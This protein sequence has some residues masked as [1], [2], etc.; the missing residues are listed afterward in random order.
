MLEELR[1]LAST[2]DNT[3]A[4]LES[5]N[6]LN[7]TGPAGFFPGIDQLLAPTRN[8]ADIA[9]KIPSIIQD[10]SSWSGG[11]GSWNTHSIANSIMQTLTNNRAMLGTAGELF[12]RNTTY[13]LGRLA[14]GWGP[15]VTPGEVGWPIYIRSAAGR[16]VESFRNMD[17][18]SMRRLGSDVA[19]YIAP[20]LQRFGQLSG[21][22]LVEALPA[23]ALG[24]VLGG[25]IN[26]VRELVTNQPNPNTNIWSGL[27]MGLWLGTGNDLNEWNS[28]ITDPANY[29]VRN[30]I[31]DINTQINPTTATTLSE[32]ATADPYAQQATGAG[33]TVRGQTV[34]NPYT[35]EAT[36]Q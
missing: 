27:D 8:F 3:E 5:I 10:Y 7:R 14:G 13:H 30:P 4:L 6:M 35:G 32:S 20:A 18:E 33:Q 34:V 31:T 12:D 22:A 28:I 36:Y 25:P 23:V 2:F 19:P 29:S 1:K 16:A 17:W 15:P 26:E 9:H 11:P 24:A 21:K